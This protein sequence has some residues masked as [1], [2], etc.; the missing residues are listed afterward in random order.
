[1]IDLAIYGILAV[2]IAAGL[3]RGFFFSFTRL[4]VF[5]LAWLI[6]LG[7]Y[8]TLAR[9]ANENTTWVGTVH[10]YT[11]DSYRIDD[12]ELWRARID[13]I[14]AATLLELENETTLPVPFDRMFAENVDKKALEHLDLYMLKDYYNYTIAFGIVNMLAFLAVFAIAYVA[15]ILMFDAVDHVFHFPVVRIWDPIGGAAI[16]LIYGL[17]M[18]GLIIS[19]LPIG[20]VIVPGDFLTN[21][22]EKSKLLSSF[23][24]YEWV[25][26]VVK[27]IF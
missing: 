7:M 8:P 13:D 6:A 23:Q 15:L 2:A 14:P 21:L 4:M 25:T 19:V 18:V 17:F 10:Y 24:R 9:W 11:E 27:G 22:L 3:Y 20:L 12:L 5:F 16:G 1:M 26:G